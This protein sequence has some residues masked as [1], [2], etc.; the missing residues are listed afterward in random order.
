MLFAL[1]LGMGANYKIWSHPL[2]TSWS[3]QADYFSTR[4]QPIFYVGS[5]SFGCCSNL[6]LQ[7]LAS[8]F[9]VGD[10]GYLRIDS[11]QNNH[12]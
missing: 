6:E 5:Y 9:R 12:K 11:H 4:R 3:F 10:V 1:I 8:L 7:V 2:R